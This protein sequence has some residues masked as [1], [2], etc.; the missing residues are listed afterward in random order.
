MPGKNKYGNTRIV[1]KTDLKRIWDTPILSPGG[2][3]RIFT[4]H[5]INLVLTLDNDILYLFSFLIYQSGHDNTIK[6]SSR[7]LIKFAPAV[8]SL[9]EKYS[10]T[11]R[12]KTSQRVLREHFKYLIE[13]GLVLPT[14]KYNVYLIN[15]NFA[16]SKLY[17]KGK[18]YDAW[19][20]AH[21]KI[22]EV[23]W[24]HPQWTERLIKESQLYINH[25]KEN[26]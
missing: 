2:T 23:F 24:M 26:L 12:I 21:Q 14:N 8:N 11:K 5:F 6:Y 25:V 4:K 1:T 13:N 3:G 16:Y 17:V 22:N 20:K 19:I 10:A 9:K 18:F 15:P 7:L